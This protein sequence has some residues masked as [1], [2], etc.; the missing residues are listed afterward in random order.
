MSKVATALRQ[1]FMASLRRLLPA[2]QEDRKVELPSG[3]RAYRCE[4]GGRLTAF[5]ILCLSSK[6]DRFTVEL[7]WSIDGHLP[8]SSILLTPGAE[9]TGESIRLSSL[10]HPQRID[11]W[12]SVGRQ[13]TLEEM[14]NFVPGQ[15][16]EEKLLDIDAKVSD[17]MTKIRDFGVPYLKGISDRFGVPASCFES[18]ALRRKEQ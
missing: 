12:W 1:Q 7:A 4:V 8:A 6:D 17:A 13:R 2:F 10:W 5:V 9:K 3:W 18:T 15:S 11:F 14:A 16:V